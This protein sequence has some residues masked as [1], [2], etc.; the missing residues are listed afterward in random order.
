MDVVSDFQDMLEALQRHNVRYLIVGGL[1]FI[2]HAKPRFTKDMDIWVDPDEA[3][4][5]HANAAL[6]EFGS[7]YLL[8][9]GKTDQILQLGLPPNRIDLMQSVGKL[10]FAEVWERRET[11]E[12]GT[13]TANWI[14]I[15]SLLEIKA[16]IQDARHQ[17]DADY[18]RKVLE[19]R[20]KRDHGV[21]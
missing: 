12:Y 16:S 6:T 10:V 20:G 17:S 18:L 9:A 14:D 1:A 3:N 7:P 19:F 15:E 5:A 8:D 4:I 21:N 11:A 2:Y 13:V